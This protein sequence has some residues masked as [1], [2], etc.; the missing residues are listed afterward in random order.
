MNTPAH[1]VA[2][3]LALSRRD[4]P[5]E[6]LPLTLGA[7]LPDAPMFLFYAWE[8]LVL[9]VPEMTLWRERYFDPGWQTF[10]DVFNSIPLIALGTLAARLAGARWDGARWWMALFVSMGVHAVIDLPLHREDAHRH[11]WPLTDWRYVSPV[12]YWHPEYYGWWVSLAEI[13]LVLV[14]AAVLWRRHPERWIRALAT[15][16][17]GLY[18]L[19]VGFAVLVWM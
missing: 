6:V 5:R 13:G 15:S 8:R 7:L 3:L 10:F 1:L 9:Q 11:F 2:N 12:S 16:I 17:A 14:G 19:F 4:R 18:L